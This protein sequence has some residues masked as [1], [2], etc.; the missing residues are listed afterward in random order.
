MDS[1]R[2]GGPFPSNQNCNQNSGVFAGNQTAGFDG[3][4]EKNF[5]PNSNSRFGNFEGEVNEANLNM[6][7]RNSNFEGP[8]FGGNFEN[9]PQ[10]QR[11]GNEERNFG[12]PQRFPCDNFRN[13]RDFNQPRFF[14]GK[15]EREMGSQNYGVTDNFDASSSRANEIGDFRIGNCPPGMQNLQN[16]LSKPKVP[17]LFDITIE[18]PPN[19]SGPNS[20]RKSKVWEKYD[21]DDYFEDPFDKRLEGRESERSEKTWT[22]AGAWAKS[23]P[24]P[25]IQPWELEKLA[26][27]KPP[28]TRPW[29]REP[30]KDNRPWMKDIPGKQEIDK[31]ELSGYVGS[32]LAKLGNFNVMPPNFAKSEG[33]QEE[34]R[35]PVSGEGNNSSQL[36]P[37]KRTN[38]NKGISQ[39]S[40]E[41]EEQTLPQNN[42]PATQG[43][44]ANIRSQNR[45]GP[46]GNFIPASARDFDQ[47]GN[48]FNDRLRDGSFAPTNF[49]H[50]DD[51]RKDTDERNRF[52]NE[53]KNF[54][55]DERICG[56]DDRLPFRRDER[57]LFGRD[58][59]RNFTRPISREDRRNFGNDDRFFGRDD[60]TFTRPS[61]DDRGFG[62]FGGRDDVDERFGNRNGR[63]GFDR[64]HRDDRDGRFFDRSSGPFDRFGR[65][66]DQP[67]S[68]PVWNPQVFDYSQGWVSN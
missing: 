44:D 33:S 18:K 3:G 14:E 34:T 21:K 64:F 63:R 51:S 60:R 25:W 38:W 39:R 40:Q 67:L 52:E 54:D 8:R 43:G 28:E 42:L 65:T 31:A 36:D 49:D 22:N 4:Q 30:K 35:Q 26:S 57:G 12:P 16:S 5:N 46:L 53:A 68:E 6:K 17:S 2:Q 56:R 20:D 23:A 11:F 15:R 7:F 29:D 45:S 62:R 58:E 10:R 66:R 32:I 24:S 59:L 61:R 27:Q 48:E 41:E 47:R 1:N 9:F 13:E 37:N 55:V 50:L 19:L